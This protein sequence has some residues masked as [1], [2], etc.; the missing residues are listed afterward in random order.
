M[1]GDSGRFLY[2]KAMVWGIS[3]ADIAE[4]VSIKRSNFAASI[5]VL[6]V[7]MLLVASEFV[8]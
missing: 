8:I 1:T 3:D 2:E 7:G 4:Y 5:K 6:I